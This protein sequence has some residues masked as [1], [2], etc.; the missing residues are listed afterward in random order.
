MPISHPG[1][2]GERDADRAA[3]AVLAT[4]SPRRALALLLSPPYAVAIEAQRQAGGSASVIPA[5]RPGG[6]DAALA[7]GL[8]SA[9]APLG[10]GA[11]SF[12]EPRFGRDFSR[13]RVHAGP[14][15]GDSA[16]ALGAIAYTVGRDIVVDRRHADLDAESGRGLLAHELAHVVQQERLA[17]GRPIVQRQ[18]ATTSPEAHPAPKPAAAARG[19]HKQDAAVPDPLLPHEVEWRAMFVEG[20]HL[21]QRLYAAYPE[22]SRIERIV[23]VA[24]AVHVAGAD[25]QLIGHYALR[26]HWRLSPGVYLMWRDHTAQLHLNFAATPIALNRDDLPEDMLK[27]LGKKDILVATDW[28]KIDP[29]VVDVDLM[30]LL[31][32]DVAAPGVQQA[33]EDTDVE[34]PLEE[35][36]GAREPGF[37]S[38][39]GSTDPAQAKAAPLPPLSA[40]IIGLRDQPLGGTGAFT[41]RLHWE[42]TSPDLLIAASWAAKPISY[43]WQLWKIDKLKPLEVKRAEAQARRGPEEKGERVGR[44][45]SYGHDTARR[46]RD[47]VQHAEQYEEDRKRALQEGRVVDELSNELNQGL[48]SVEILHTVG[49]QVFDTVAKLF[50]DHREREVDWSRGAGY[51]ILRSVAWIDPAAAKEGRKWRPPSV[52]AMVIHV[53]DLQQLSREAS[54]EG[55]ASLASAQALAKG[56][57]QF[58]KQAGID[59]ASDPALVRAINQVKD[60]ELVVGGSAEAVI[61]AEYEKRKADYEKARAQS[62]LIAA[63][64]SDRDVDRLER[65]VDMLEAQLKLAEKRS[66]QLSL[67]GAR[68]VRRV[69]T[70]LVSRITGQKYPLLIQVAEPRRV[71]NGPYE[72][73]ISDVTTPDGGKGEGSHPTDP[74][75]AV[76]A[77]FTDFAHHEGSESYGEG[78]LT[79]RLPVDFGPAETPML[80]RRPLTDA[81]RIGTFPV[82]PHDAKVAKKRLEELAAILG[83]LAAIAAPEL[84]LPGALIGGA[85]A[86]AHIYERWKN[87]TLRPDASLVSDVLSILSALTATTSTLGRLTKVSLADGRFVLVVTEEGGTISTAAQSFDKWALNPASVLWGNAQIVDALIAINGQEEAGTLS[88]TDAARKRAELFVHGLGQN[89][90]FITHLRGPKGA[91]EEPLPEGGPSPARPPGQPG[92]PGREVERPVEPTSERKPPTTLEPPPTTAPGSERS[93][94]EIPLIELPDD[95]VIYQDKSQ[96]MTEAEAKGILRNATADDSTREVAILVDDETGEYIV[97]QGSRG[98]VEDR[99][100]FNRAMADYIRERGAPGRWRLREHF[101]PPD[102]TGATPVEQR[103]PSGRGGDFERAR[104]DS[105]AAGGRA[106]EAELT[107]W[108]EDGE[109]QVVYGYDRS[110][111]K[112]YWLRWVDEDGNS[113]LE[114][115]AD[116]DAYAAWFRR[117]FHTS[118][119]V[120]E[121][122]G[123]SAPPGRSRPGRRPPDPRR[124][125]KRPART[126]EPSEPAATERVP[127]AG[128]GPAPPAAEPTAREELSSR[129]PDVARRFADA[130]LR[131]ADSEAEGP[132]PSEQ[133]DSAMRALE[134]AG[135]GPEGRALVERIFQ[136]AKGTKELSQTRFREALNKLA[137]LASLVRERPDLLKAAGRR[138]V[139]RSVLDI[140]HEVIETYRRREARPGRPRVPSERLQEAVHAMRQA[141]LDYNEAPTDDPVERLEALLRLQDQVIG[142][143]AEVLRWLDPSF[144]ADTATGPLTDSSELSGLQE[145]TIDV[146]AA[147][148]VGEP[149]SRDLPGVGLERYMLT[150]SEIAE[151]HTDPA[152]LAEQLAGLLR[153]Y[154]RAHLVGPGFGGELFEGMMLAPEKMNLEAQNK[155][156]EAFIRSSRAAGID[157]SVDV[158]ASGRR[159]VIPLAEGGVEHVDVLTRVDYTITGTMGDHPPQT[160]RVVIEVGPPPNGAVRVVESTIPSNVRGGDV[161]Q[162][163]GPGRGGPAARQPGQ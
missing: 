59:P 95:T 68:A 124:K 153:G 93:I 140:A 92:P 37:G 61:R 13:V 64:F 87:D 149:I 51:Y 56:L 54:G 134:D 126:E 36:V 156:V 98:L 97:I 3:D 16:R 46:W 67:D 121:G 135:V 132:A 104:A 151:L 41:M 11:R 148:S 20:Q 29:S 2:S 96:P 34:A 31:V 118:P 136:P 33:T 18:A 127:G 14:A 6:V 15:A 89:I 85:V 83:I 123:I 50:A 1:D 12:M 131:H 84:A 137:R 143:V 62:P 110:R 75:A 119:D 22:L 79:V 144:R 52:A 105:S 57:E 47:L 24:N 163:L 19:K 28:I 125:T 23:A 160:Y 108:T 99:A 109:Q 101:H 122:S 100:R 40:E 112:P 43:G 147:G 30:L 60:L 90:G 17:G 91:R 66:K 80:W 116:L 128:G 82:S 44:W 107:F 55:E 7:A 9:S 72:T 21:A 157:V 53:Q 106:V 76:W 86:A 39:V 113:H 58:D 120:A 162:R 102:T 35:D 117:R 38:E 71:G 146:T 142:R 88:S 159:L 154:Q 145:Q 158:H 5:P 94:D 42:E 115:F 150:P 139:Y 73:V 45:D 70:T 141:F 10:V 4:D 63:G 49:E 161:L 111:S 32:T 74:I 65:E 114:E 129:R 152:D 26:S 130:D 77:A 27:R 48:Y 138:H 25:G 69:Q 155:G 133:F 103:Y 81:E 8:G 78:S